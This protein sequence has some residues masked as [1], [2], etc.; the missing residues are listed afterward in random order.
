MIKWMPY[1]SFEIQTELSPKQVREKLGIITKRSWEKMRRQGIVF[2]GEITSDGFQLTRCL[3]YRNSFQP[4]IYGTIRLTENGCVI[5]IE[6]K[7]NGFV[8][9]IVY[10]WFFGLLFLILVMALTH[11]NYSALIC[12]CIM[13]VGAYFVIHMAFLFEA[14]HTK[15]LL[16]K[17]IN[18]MNSGE[19]EY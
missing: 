10:L 6:Q 5:Q 17:Y 19:I 13:G 16:K 3:A 2:S 15:L 11:I 9:K 18:K 8:K 12:C 1:D 4:V 7:L 14:R